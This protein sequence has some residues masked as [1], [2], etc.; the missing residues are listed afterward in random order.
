MRS[1]V[2][3]EIN[4]HGHTR[5]MDGVRR[6]YNERG[7]N[8][9][10]DVALAELLA[11]LKADEAYS[12]KLSA[13]SRSNYIASQ[14]IGSIIGANHAAAADANRELAQAGERVDG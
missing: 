1:F 6:L 10:A 2:E 5:V 12:D 8:I 14:I 9:L 4:E 13:E 11:M 3:H 7:L